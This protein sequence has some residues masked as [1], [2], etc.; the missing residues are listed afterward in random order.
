ME[1][2]DQQ[3]SVDYEHAIGPN[4]D[5]YMRKFERFDTGGSKATW[6]WPAFFATAPWFIYRRMW[7]PGLLSLF[8]PFLALI[9]AGIALAVL[10]PAP[11]V[12]VATCLACLLLPSVMLATFANSMYWRHV[13]RLIRNLPS[14]SAQHPEFRHSIL[15]QGGGTGLLGMIGVLVGVGFGGIFG[16]GMLAAIS[17]P[18]Y[19][20]YTIRAQTSEGLNLAAPLKAAV[21]EFYTENGQ[22]PDQS[23]LG[24]VIP[25]GQYVSQVTVESGSLVISYGNKAN[26][27]IAGKRVALL[28]GL[29]DSGDVVWACGYASLPEGVTPA[30][31]PSGSEVAPK[32]LPSACR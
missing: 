26:S 5:Y 13:N 4:R 16:I 10:K 2:L 18:A 6:H 17:I 15:A 29:T 14:S 25:G 23:D 3:R 32:Y 22:W 30:E 19:Q 24:E 1:N 8:L 12:W 28:P 21:A 7:V 20:D 9:A 27:N 31:G 11:A